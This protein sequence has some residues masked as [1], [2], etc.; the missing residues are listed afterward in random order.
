MDHIVK[1]SLPFGNTHHIQIC[2]GKNPFGKQWE[3]SE[4]D[5]GQMGE[6]QEIDKS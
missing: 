3:A 2:Y 6:K 5:K 1:C 4:G